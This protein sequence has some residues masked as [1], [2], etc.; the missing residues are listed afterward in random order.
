MDEYLTLQKAGKS[1]QEAYEIMVESIKKPTKH[2]TGGLI[3]GY[4]T[5]GVS[6]LFRSR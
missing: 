2:A 4:A 1:E 3:P 5:G 6:N